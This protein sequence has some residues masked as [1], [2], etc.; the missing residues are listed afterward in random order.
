MKLI[1]VEPFFNSPSLKIKVPTD[2]KGFEHQN[3]VPK[4]L[5]FE[6]GT[7]P[8][9]AGLTEAEK[10]LVQQVVRGQRPRAIFDVDA[11][12]GRIARVDAEVAAEVKAKEAASAANISLEEKIAGAVASALAQAGL[13]KKAA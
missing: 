11:N 3:Q 1:A 5:R 13:V 8:D 7:A 4:G 6:I 2:A 10:V 12:K 9:Y